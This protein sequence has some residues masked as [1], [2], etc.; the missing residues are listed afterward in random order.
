MRIVTL[1]LCAVLLAALAGN[2]GKRLLRTREGAASPVVDCV[3]EPV[4]VDLQTRSLLADVTVTLK[5]WEEKPAL[6]LEAGETSAEFPLTAAENGVFIGSVAVPLEPL[7]GFQLYLTAEKYGQ[8][9]IRERL[10][11][12]NHISTLLPLRMTSSGYSDPQYQDGTFQMTGWASAEIASQ[13]R[14][15]IEVDA[16]EFRLYRNGELLRTVPGERDWNVIGKAEAD[17]YIPEE[18]ED[19]TVDCGK[20]DQVMLTF[21]C[22]G[23]N[24]LGWE[25]TIAHFQVKDGDVETVR[26]DEDIDPILT[27]PE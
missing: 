5:D 7:S 25:F 11:R 2:L 10:G 16:P 18:Q 22:R 20:G 13:D 9:L 1:A 24:G 27:W 17:G 19:W 4:G 14:D 3:V 12:W 21:A 23:E 15:D 26:L 8:A 6:L